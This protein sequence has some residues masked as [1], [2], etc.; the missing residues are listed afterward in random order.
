VREA[1]AAESRPQTGTVFFI[2]R[3]DLST[4]LNLLNVKRQ[5]KYIINRR[6]EKETWRG[7]G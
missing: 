4:A 1:L 2:D 7:K 5:N 3:R 6:E